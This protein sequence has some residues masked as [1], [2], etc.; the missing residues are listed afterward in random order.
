[1]PKKVLFPTLFEALALPCVELLYPLKAAGLEEIVLLHVIDRDDV[2]YV[3]FG[4]FDRGEA[5]D[6][7]DRAQLRFA[8]WARSVEGAGLR[9]TRVVETGRPAAK[10]LEVAAREEVDL[11][12]TGRQRHLPLDA[13]YLGGTS[14]EVL[15]RSP[16]P[17]LVLKSCDRGLCAAGGAA[18]FRL[19]LATDL[20]PASEPALAFVRG[21]RGAAPR[22]D[23]VHV[24][25]KDELE[26][27]DETGLEREQAAR[28]ERIEGI[29]A[30]LRADGFTAD[31]H[32]RG[33]EVADEVLGAAA[34]LQST[35]IV[36]G[37]TEKQWL[38]ELLHGSPSHRL[39]ELSPVPVLLVPAA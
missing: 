36:T 30:G 10:I 38:Q 16:V 20:A 22:V 11:I 4:G 12:V 6:L 1:M 13:A 35:L 39:A 2:G 21:L 9:C 17:V 27:L 18:P 5:E 14:L 24:V 25:R 37:T 7:K 8:D 15:R 23:V 3:P 32:V 26:K 31:G 28:R 29:C 34:D 33:G 19:L